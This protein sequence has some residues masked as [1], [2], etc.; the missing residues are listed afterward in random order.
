MDD[1]MDNLEVLRLA[2]RALLV[3]E[4][5]QDEVECLVD[6]VLQLA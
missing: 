1:W 4:K 2:F 3:E 6:A 5:Q